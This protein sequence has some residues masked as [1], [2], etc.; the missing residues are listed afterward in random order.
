MSKNLHGF[1]NFNGTLRKDVF[2]NNIKS[3]K[4]KNFTLSLSL[5]LVDAGFDGIE[6]KY[7]KVSVSI[8]G[9]NSQPFHKLFSWYLLFDILFVFQDFAIFCYILIVVQ[10]CFSTSISYILTIMQSV[11]WYLIYYILTVM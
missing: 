3:R 2:H 11:S 6:S 7:S 10:G 5:S 9:G 8:L 4:K 1:R